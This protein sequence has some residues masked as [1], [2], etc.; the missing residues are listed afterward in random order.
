[1]ADLIIIWMSNYIHT[2]MLFNS[3]QVSLFILCNVD[4]I[5]IDGSLKNSGIWISYLDFG[6]VQSLMKANYEFNFAAG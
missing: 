6:F 1:M 5:M 3:L 4:P 2:W